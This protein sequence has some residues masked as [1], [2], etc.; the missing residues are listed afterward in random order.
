MIL[1]YH[2]L[3]YEL[4]LEEEYIEFEISFIENRSVKYNIS[5]NNAKLKDVPINDSING[6]IIIITITTIII[7]DHGTKISVPSVSK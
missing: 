4:K 3:Y 7:V 6:M 1:S 2:E 5:Y